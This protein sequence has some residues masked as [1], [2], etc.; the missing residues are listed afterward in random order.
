M[1]IYT[2]GPRQCPQIVTRSGAGPGGHFKGGDYQQ[3]GVCLSA[4]PEREYLS[5]L[6]SSDCWHCV[7]LDTI[8][9]TGKYF[10]DEEFLCLDRERNNV[11]WRVKHSPDIIFGVSNQ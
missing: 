4:G 1:F 9:Q 10:S 11:V 2:P 5:Q 8:A 6:G 3:A 7:T